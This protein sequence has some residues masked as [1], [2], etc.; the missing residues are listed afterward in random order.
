MKITPQ[1]DVTSAGYPACR[2]LKPLQM[3]A[4]TALACAVTSCIQTQQRTGGVPPMIPDGHPT[5]SDGK[6]VQKTPGKPSVKKRI[7]SPASAKGKPSPQNIPTAQSTSSIA[8]SIPDEE[9][10]PFAAP[11]QPLR[12]MGRISIE[13]VEDRT[14]RGT[15]IEIGSDTH[16]NKS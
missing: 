12:L 5:E 3:A 7:P 8:P 13:P 2:H 10:D 4:L 11:A 9:T 14:N 6:T 15:I 16:P 1:H